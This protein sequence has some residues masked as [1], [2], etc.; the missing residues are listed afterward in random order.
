MTRFNSLDIGEKYAER[1]SPALLR[2]GKLQKI[3]KTYG[4]LKK[5]E[6][7]IRND[8]VKIKKE[9]EKNLQRYEELLSRLGVC[10]TCLQPIGKDAVR[11][12]KSHFK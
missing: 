9:K 6:M 10:P 2:L 5:Q 7:M 3:S 8:L 11:H 12:I 1:I 4:Q